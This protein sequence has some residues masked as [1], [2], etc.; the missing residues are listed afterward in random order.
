MSKY[1]ILF[2]NLSNCQELILKETCFVTT[3]SL[4]NSKIEQLLLYLGIFIVELNS[5]L[6]G[7]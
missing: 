1:V 2:L 5:Q 3:F 7:L 4:H 6:V